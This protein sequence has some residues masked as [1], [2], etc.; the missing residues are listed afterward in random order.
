VVVTAG[1]PA[2][3]AAAP[4]PWVECL[5]HQPAA[6]AA[7][8]FGWGAGHPP[9]GL[10]RDLRP[11]DAR[12]L[13]W[14][15]APLAEPLEI[16][17][18][19]AAVLH[20]A[21]DAPVAHL[22]VRLADVAPDGT[23]AQVSVG[24]LNLAHRDS[25]KAPEPLQPGR[26]YAVRVPLRSAGY[27]WRAGHR[28]R[29]SVASAWWPAIWPSPYPC[30]IE[31]HAGPGS[32]SHLELPVL[33]AAVAAALP[34]APD[35]KAPPTGLAE[36]DTGTTLEPEWRIE[37]DVI[38]RT[39]TIRSFE[40]GTTVHPDGR[41]SLYSDER[42][43]MTAHE[44]DPGRA[45]FGS[46]VVYRWDDGESLTEIRATGDIRGTA[47]DFEIRLGLEVTCDGS[48]FWARTWEETVPRHL[49]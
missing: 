20:V 12:A 6:G 23:S 8:S 38:A 36:L 10:A 1:A 44:V 27:R 29:L 30:T 48:P 31:I 13:A 34:A 25:D 5:R 45:R 35:W 42:L 22:V 47:T 40:G 7:G 24:L 26:V 32:P 21:V 19:P 3:A 17:G 39:R 43:E 33:P 18:F 16:I 9:N 46:E 41:R 15:S 14:T 11:D 2:G 37:D 4:R 49:V 28:V